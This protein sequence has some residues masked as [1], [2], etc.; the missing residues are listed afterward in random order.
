MI[1]LLRLIYFFS[2]IR[3]HFNKVGTGAHRARSS[4]S[5]EGEIR[6]LRKNLINPFGGAEEDKS[7]P[8][9]FDYR[10]PILLDFPINL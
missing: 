3:Y 10:I 7:L 8:F 6:S 9:Q 2:L 1:V 4:T 5:G